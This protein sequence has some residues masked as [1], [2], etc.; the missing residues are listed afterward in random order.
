MIL[1]NEKIRVRKSILSSM[2]LWGY[3]NLSI[4]LNGFY[5]EKLTE[6]RLTLGRINVY[7]TRTIVW[8]P[9]ATTLTN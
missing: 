6:N 9:I 5:G 3:R 7:W 2:D 1:S 8:L 4:E